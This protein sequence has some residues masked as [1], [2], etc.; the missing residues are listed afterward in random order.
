MGT[1]FSKVSLILKLGKHSKKF[2]RRERISFI[3]AFRFPHCWRDVAMD[4]FWA[5]FFIKCFTR[6]RLF[7]IICIYLAFFNDQRYRNYFHFNFERCLHHV[8]CP[9]NYSA[10]R[11][12][13][14][15]F[16][17]YCY[18]AYYW[19]ECRLCSALSCSLC[20]KRPWRI[21]NKFWG[22]RTF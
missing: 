15:N 6:S 18:R 1:F 13:N 11:M 16:W 2:Q 7:F 3:Y 5:S 10:Q 21:K 9:N 12:G 14:G 17:K 4:V 20:K 8:K 22:K 19:V